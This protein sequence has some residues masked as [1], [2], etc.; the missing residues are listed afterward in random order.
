MIRR[1]TN[2]CAKSTIHV[3]HIRVIPTIAATG[4]GSTSMSVLRDSQKGILVLSCAVFVICI[5][6]T[7]HVRYFALMQCLLNTYLIRA[8]SSINPLP[9]PL[10]GTPRAYCTSKPFDLDI[11]YPELGKYIDQIR[12][13]FPASTCRSGVAFCGACLQYV[14]VNGPLRNSSRPVV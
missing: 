4:P 11:S 9:P 10:G 12:V 8:P 14:F 5:I 7:A 6:T 13:Q 2:V 1:A 3:T